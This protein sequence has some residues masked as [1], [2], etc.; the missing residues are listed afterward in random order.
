M[1]EEQGRQ[2]ETPRRIALTR[3]AV[4]YRD[5]AVVLADVLRDEAAIIRRAGFRPH[6][7][8][9]QQDDGL[10]LEANLWSQE[11]PHLTDYLNAAL[12]LFGD[13]PGSLSW[14]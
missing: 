13:E 4:R 5:G 11:T 10:V 2:I 8:Q 9:L 6:A 3:A 1:S 7:L 14:E 12:L